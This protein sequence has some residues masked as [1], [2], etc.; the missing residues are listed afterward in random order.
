MNNSKLSKTQKF[1][2]WLN[3]GYAVYIIMTVIVFIFLIIA[4]ISHKLGVTDVIE[5][6]AFSA[7][8]LE[9]TLIALSNALCKKLAKKVE[10]PSKL[11]TDYVSLVYDLYSKS[12]DKMLE[13]GNSITRIDKK[14][15][16]I[17][18]KELMPITFEGWIHDKKIIIEDRASY[19][20]K[21]P[22]MIIRYYEKL[23]NAHRSSNT[24]NNIN[25][26][27]DSWSVEEGLFKIHSSRTTYYNHL[28]T[29]RAMDYEL[30][31]GITVRT[32]FEC[33]PYINNLEN[34]LL[35]NHLGINGFV[36]SSDGYVVFIKRGDNISVGKDVWENSVSASLKTKYSLDSQNRF[37]YSNMVNGIL[38]EIEDELFIIPEQLTG[39]GSST[40]KI[41]LIS[42]YRDLVEGGKP[43]FMFYTICAMKKEDI[44]K[45]FNDG[46]VNLKGERRKAS[47]YTKK[48]ELDMQI[49]GKE[50][51]FIL[52]DD[53]CNHTHINMDKIT[54]NDKEVYPML[55]SYASCILMLKNY[56][57]EHTSIYNE[58][59]HMAKTS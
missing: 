12:Q 49:D 20:Y 1:I 43:H 51:D 52:L 18:E 37:S 53:L 38:S 54:V 2:M 32:L 40:E 45:C 55:P 26:R 17:V 56:F 11:S 36:I 50:I 25:I 33:G 3:N 21:L 58:I 24:Y 48:K 39:S 46:K 47:S 59:I 15:Q 30:D 7:V 42:A 14:G 35:S 4:V 13:T 41:K 23:L 34:S 10:D 28:V 29:N 31:K 19:D 44:K 8:L 22:D 5:F 27:I 57:K 6:S 16:E 9:G